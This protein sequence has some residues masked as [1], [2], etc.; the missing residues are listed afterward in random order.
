MAL[1]EDNE[2][3]WYWFDADGSMAKSKDV[4]VPESN[5][6]RANGKWVRYDENGHMIKG[7]DNRQVD[8][9]WG[10]WYFDPGYR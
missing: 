3:Y 6:N 9:E 5:E 1:L 4:Y 7:E 8:G 2:Y 10:W